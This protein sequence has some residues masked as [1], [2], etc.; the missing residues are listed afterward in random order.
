M[1]RGAM[2][3]QDEIPLPGSD[4]RNCEKILEN[5]FESVLLFQGGND[6]INR[7][8]HIVLAKPE[9]LAQVSKYG[10]EIVGHDVKHDFM[11]VRFKT[12]FIT[13]CDGNNSGRIAAISISN[14]DNQISHSYTLDIS[15]AN[16]PCRNSHCEH[17]TEFH[18]FN[19]GNGFFQIKPCA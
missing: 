5:N 18:K 7:N 13:F 6:K 1:I 14:T 3:G 2:T 8:Y 4:W 9:G 11:S 12:S 17:P 15:R 10:N 19:D 16:I